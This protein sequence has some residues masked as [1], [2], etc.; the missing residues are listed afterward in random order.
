[1]DE[2]A[3]EKIAE[4]KQRLLEA[5]RRLDE[6][7]RRLDEARRQRE[8]AETRAAQAERAVLPTTLTGTRG[9]TTRPTGRLYPKRIIPWEGFATRQR[10]IWE[11]LSNSSFSSSR[12]FPSPHQ[13]DYVRSMLAPVGCEASLR[14]VAR[15]VVQDAVK[16]LVR[17]VYHDP[18]LQVQLNLRGIVTFESQF[19]EEGPVR[20]V[21]Q[22]ADGQNGLT[23]EI[24]PD[25][26]I[27]CDDESVEYLSKRLMAAVV[28]QCFSYMIRHGLQDGYIFTGEAVIFLH[29][30][31]DPTTVYYHICIP[32]LDVSEDDDD[33]LY[34]TALAQV[35]A[36]TLHAL[37]TDPPPQAWFDATAGLKT[38]AV[39]YVDILKKIPKTKRKPGQLPSSYK[40]EKWEESAC[41][42]I[43]TPARCAQA[44]ETGP[45]HNDALDAE[46]QVS[47]KER[48]FCTH[49]CLLGLLYGSTLD[50][51]CPNMASHR[52]EHLPQDQFLHLIR[53]QLATDRGSDA[54]CYPLYLK[55]SRGALFKVRLSSHGYTLIAKGMESHQEHLNHERNMYT[56]ALKVQ[57][58]CIPVCVGKTSLLRPYYHSGG[59]Y[60]HML[61]LSWAGK[62]LFKYISPDNRS[63]YKRKAARALQGLHQ[64]NVIHG[65]AAL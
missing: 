47:I 54:D 59:K 52:K 35:F 14:H 64:Q 61:F 60:M 32:S 23:G 4:E 41:A 10:T 65:D 40:T 18:A 17:E 33:R 44:A 21:Y 29:I 38:W 3:E 63:F 5:L 8:E 50:P 57:G 30:P 58:A 53:T 31:E 6:E 16:K 43:P 34:R 51:A 20:C 22:Q 48:P 15:S 46:S 13:L 24:L 1:M 37:A 45:R 39:E 7:D 25:D 28:T 42:P 55:G 9:D 56:H 49:K 36:F 11:K 12:V 2:I 27:N 26:I 62:P 19:I